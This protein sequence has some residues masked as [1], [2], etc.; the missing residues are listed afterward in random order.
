MI[1]LQNKIINN[2]QID[3]IESNIIPTDL[4]YIR[5]KYFKIEDIVNIVK[6]NNSVPNKSYVK[7]NGFVVKITS[8]RLRIMIGKINNLYSNIIP[9]YFILERA[10]TDSTAYINHLNLYGWKNNDFVMI[11]RSHIVY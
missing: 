3:E 8:E 1:R 5:E 7:I 9:V 11:T 4:H 6:E 10:K 2:Y